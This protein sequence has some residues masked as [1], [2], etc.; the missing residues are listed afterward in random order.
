[1]AELTLLLLA[2][3]APPDAPPPPAAPTPVAPAT[4]IKPHVVRIKD[5]YEAYQARVYDQALQGFLDL[6]VE[7]PNDAA[8]MLNVGST[9]YQMK[10]FAEAEKAFNQAAL[11]G[12]N[13]QR[14][15]AL[16][17]LGNCAFR[18][19]KLEEA[20]AR[21]QAALELDPNDADAKFNLEFTRDEIRRRHEQAQKQQKEHPEQ[22]QQQQGQEGAPE[23]QQ[24]P[25]GGQP[26]EGAADPNR[27]TDRDGLTDA[28]ER[29]ATN[30]TDPNNADTDGDGRSDAQED[31]NK[32]GRVDAGETDPRQ[33]DAGP[34]PQRE[35][36][37]GEDKAGEQPGSGSAPAQGMTREQAERYLD[38]L[39]DARPKHAVPGGG[40]RAPGGKDW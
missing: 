16:Y 31:A 12:T 35:G 37:P 2:L 3:A 18:Q 29:N 39:G 17:N 32:N 33:T 10:S 5:P 24:Q 6:Q 20:L 28:Q 13:P 36:Q 1:V 14:Q 9:Y 30:P 8:L 7:H 21:F 26:P 15:R 40:R 23:P 4:G 19:G 34:A 27:D 25:E 22:Q 38:G 11:A